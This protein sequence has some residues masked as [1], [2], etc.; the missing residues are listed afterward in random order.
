[1]HRQG[2][3]RRVK[4]YEGRWG[5]DA[6]SANASVSRITLWC[7]CG[8][9]HVHVEWPSF[10]SREAAIAMAGQVGVLSPCPHCGEV[11]APVPA[12]T[13]RTR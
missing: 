2:I 10:V 5:P 12:S 8:F 13:E 7:P 11:P 3:R 9:H 4:S 1:M 6:L